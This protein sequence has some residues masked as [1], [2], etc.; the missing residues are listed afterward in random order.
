MKKLSPQQIAQ[1]HR[2]LMANGS[3]DALLLELVDHLACEVEHYMWIGLSFETA[4]EKVLLEANPKAV[5]Y[6]TETYKRELIIAEESLQTASLDDIVFEFRNKAYGAYN[7]RQGYQASLR[8][9]LL[10]GVGIFL[11]I[12]GLSLGLKQGKWTYLSLWGM[13]W[14]VGLSS[15]VFSFVSWYIQRLRHQYSMPEEA[16]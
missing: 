14:L 6:L 3:D 7:L 2:H 13:M 1:L 4:I 16:A 8:D 9:A 10:A 15:L 12:L 5:A 11:M